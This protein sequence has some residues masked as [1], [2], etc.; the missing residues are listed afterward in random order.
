MS[1][2][3]PRSPSRS[4]VGRHRVGE[5]PARVDAVVA[6]RRLLNSDD[7]FPLPAF[8]RNS[9]PRTSVI[10]FFE[11]TGWSFLRGC[12]RPVLRSRRLRKSGREVCAPRREK[13]RA[14]FFLMCDDVDAFVSHLKRKESP[15]SGQNAGGAAHKLEAAVRGS[16]GVQ[17]VRS[18]K[19]RLSRPKSRHEKET[20]AGD[21]PPPRNSFPAY[22][23][24]RRGGRPAPCPEISTLG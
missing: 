1:S 8:A 6:T 7:S 20:L 21:R 19:P 2:S 15:A 3:R 17:R 24:K 11:L 13:R 16:G 5:K 4:S 9:R 12:R 18:P 22:E 10:S 14:Q 23:A